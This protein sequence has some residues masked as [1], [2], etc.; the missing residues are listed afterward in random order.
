M[1]DIATA[2]TEMTEP[3]TPVMRR[4]F[5]RRA[6][7]EWSVADWCIA[8]SS[9]TLAISSASFFSWSYVISVRTPDYFQQAALARMTPKL[10]AIETGSVSEEIQTDAMPA[11]AIVRDR[12]PTPGDYQI[13]MIF[14][15]EAMLATR[16][17]LVRVK[18]GSTVPG[19]G[20]VQA[21]EG[22]ALG[23]TVKADMATLR[24]ASATD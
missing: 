9:V 22:T 1:S 12:A 6:D 23:G 19:L 10:D 7:G 24:S 18:V 15:D 3:S 16:E 14:K 4:G 5:L 21:I 2:P 17:E 8:L 20:T 13:V 11:Q